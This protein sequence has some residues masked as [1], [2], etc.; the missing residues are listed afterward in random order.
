MYGDLAAFNLRHI[1]HIIDQ[2]QKVVAGEPDFVQAV[3]YTF[4]ILEVGVGNLRH[5]GNHIHGCTYIM[6]HPGE[7]LR[8][9]RVRQLGGLQCRIEHFR[10]LFQLV[11]EFSK[12]CN[13]RNVNKHH[14]VNRII[15]NGVNTGAMELQ[16]AV[17][18]MLILD[19]DGFIQFQCLPPP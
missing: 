11:L 16:P 17:P 4:R 12:L 18:A 5:P 1:Q 13:I 9:G 14:Q 6:A 3:L 8:L 10:A 2:A 7:E 19:T 15:G